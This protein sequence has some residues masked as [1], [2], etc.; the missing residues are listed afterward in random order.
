MTRSTAFDTAHFL[1]GS[2]IRLQMHR[3]PPA[4]PRV[5]PPPC[6]SPPSSTPIPVIVSSP[7]LIQPGLGPVIRRIQ[8]Q[9]I[10]KKEIALRRRLRSSQVSSA[11]AAFL[12]AATISH[13]S[14]APSSPPL[15]HIS[16]ICSSLSSL[17]ALSPPASSASSPPYSPAL[18]LS[19]L[20]SV[21]SGSSGSNS[22][23]V[24]G[25]DDVSVS[26]VGGYSA[27][28]SS[29]VGVDGVGREEEEEEK[30]EGDD[31][32]EVDWRFG[33]REYMDVDWWEGDM[34]V[35]I[36][37]PMAHQFGFKEEFIL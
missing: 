24:S 17:S 1:N 10:S 13:G 25:V 15:F 12:V 20:S 7:S 23:L 5:R 9:V 34:E 14:S 32:M 16:S 4:P 31:P 35:D 33:D 36:P 3:P 2:R 29:D 37:P 28:V 8:K 26:S 6:M 18:S 21:S 11:R 22:S 19:S 27:G 30:G